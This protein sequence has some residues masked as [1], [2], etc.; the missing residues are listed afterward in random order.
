MPTV[1]DD[2]G[3][4]KNERQSLHFLFFYALAVAGGAIGYVPFL[5]LLLPLQ[6]TQQFGGE[7]LDIL[8]YAAFAGAIA[9][10]CANIFFGWLSDI[11]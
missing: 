10:S 1:N 7:A 4:G 2:A 9:A 5:T 8:A 3:S 11:T 6:A